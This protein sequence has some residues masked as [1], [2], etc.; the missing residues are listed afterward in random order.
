MKEIILVR[1]GKSSW[2][3]RVS[4]RDRPLQER[5]I[6]DAH[7]VAG[8]LR[9]LPGPDAVFS[10]PANRALHTC[11]ILMRELRIPLELLRL[12]EALYDFSGGSVEAFVRGMDDSLGRVMLFGHNHAFTALANA[13]GDRYIDNVPTTGMVHLRFEAGRWAD[14]SKGRTH[15]VVFPKNLK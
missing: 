10:S 11:T 12:S 2:D 3:Y 9:G 7:L 14:V 8:A 5:G 4:D 6:K 15:A 1:H 13:W